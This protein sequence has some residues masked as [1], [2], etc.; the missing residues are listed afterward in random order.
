MDFFDRQEAAR[1]TSK[2]LVVLFAR[3][4]ELKEGVGMKDI[5]DIF[6]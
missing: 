6:A 2:R 1:K 3:L 5:A 4:K